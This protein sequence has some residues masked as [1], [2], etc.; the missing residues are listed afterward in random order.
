[1][2]AINSLQMVHE[3]EDR[4]TWRKRLLQLLG[5]VVVLE[6][7][8]VEVSLAADLE[9]GLVD[10][11]AAVLLYPRSCF[12]HRQH[13]VPSITILSSIPLSPHPPNISV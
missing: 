1:M 7:E 13:I 12:V 2:S 6:H 3:C 8:S 11:G 5:L 9:L 10:T 4:H